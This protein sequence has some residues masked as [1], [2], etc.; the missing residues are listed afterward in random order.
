MYQ[1][2][3]EGRPT[4]MAFANDSK[5]ASAYRHRSNGRPQID[6]A[7]DPTIALIAAR[8]EDCVA[9]LMQA[10]FDVTD[11]LDA[12][13]FTAIPYCTRGH[14]DAFPDMDVE[15]ACREV[16]AQLL[17]QCRHG[18]SGFHSQDRLG[19]TQQ[20]ESKRTF[21]MDDANGNCQTRFLN[22]LNTLRQWKSVCQE[23]MYSDAKISNL[24]NAPATILY[25]K[26]TQARANKTKAETNKKRKAAQEQLQAE[27]VLGTQPPGPGPS[28]DTASAPARRS[29]GKAKCT[30]LGPTQILTNTV[31]KARSKRPRKDQNLDRQ[32]GPPAA[33]NNAGSNQVQPVEAHD[34]GDSDQDASKVTNDSLQ[35]GAG[36]AH[37]PSVP[38]ASTIQSP[39]HYAVAPL[40]PNGTTYGFEDAEN[41]KL[42]ED[43]ARS[44]LGEDLGAESST[45]NIS[46]DH[47]CAQADT[48]SH[49]PHTSSLDNDF[50]SYPAFDPRYLD[51][52][53]PIPFPPIPGD[54]EPT[55]GGHSYN[56][57]DPTL[58]GDEGMSLLTQ[59]AMADARVDPLTF[60]STMRPTSAISIPPEMNV[61]AASFQANVMGSMP[62]QPTP[63]ASAQPMPPAA[64]PNGQPTMQQNNA[65]RGSKRGRNEDEKEQGQRSPRRRR[66]D[67]YSVYH[68]IGDGDS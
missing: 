65:P 52:D 47:A 29:K 45:N 5:G 34:T 59:P 51:P 14:R 55:V 38:S 28:P 10:F 33:S 39:A 50:S 57:T 12:P 13:T 41:A 48:T 17:R 2:D 40:P 22:V 27:T 37:Q 36:P 19:R 31:P 26:S 54:E 21:Q 11:I 49:I 62:A 68:P 18:F 25:D 4:R 9:D 63:P 42:F 67:S 53:F 46:H 43:I 6:P 66:R 32:Q 8:E 64:V 60:P 16:Y 3:A 24:V 23:V 20:G 35:T 1:F 15:A 44:S 58:D 7:Q 30:Q 61:P 56:V